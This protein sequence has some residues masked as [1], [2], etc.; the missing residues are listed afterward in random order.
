MNALVLVLLAAAASAKPQFPAVRLAGPGFFVGE[1]A[2]RSSGFQGNNFQQGNNNQ[3]NQF[4]GSFSNSQLQSEFQQSSQFQTA[5][6]QLAAQ[7]RNTN[8]EFPID[9][10][11]EPLNLPSGAS[12]LMRQIDTSFSCGDRPYGY[13]ADE[14]NNCQVFHVCNPYLYSDGRIEAV[15]HSFMCNEGLRFDQKEL[16]CVEQ[17]AAIPCAESSF[18]YSRNEEFGLPEEK[19]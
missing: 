7:L 6:A 15:Q 2:F 1:S 9:G 8:S 10:V 12:L 4:Q 17:Y 13:Y 11:F 18:H 5:N 3:N 14:G 19:F 16:T